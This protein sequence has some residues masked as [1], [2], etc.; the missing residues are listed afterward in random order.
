MEEGMKKTLLATLAAFIAGFGLGWVAKW[1]KF[2]FVVAFVMLCWKVFYPA[3][4]QSVKLTQLQS[5]LHVYEQRDAKA[6]EEAKAEERK[7]YEEMRSKVNDLESDI[8][9]RKE[10]IAQHWGVREGMQVKI[11]ALEK[12]LK[13]CKYAHSMRNAELQQC[14]EKVTDVPFPKGFT[15]VLHKNGGP[16]HSSVHS[17]MVGRSND[18]YPSCSLIYRGKLNRGRS[19]FTCEVY[20]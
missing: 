12:N 11:E 2:I 6:A 14:K 1:L 5:Q 8:R 17:C 9:H 19:D 13:Q 20:E 4:E 16:A 15:C 7:K 18:G 3:A 10:L